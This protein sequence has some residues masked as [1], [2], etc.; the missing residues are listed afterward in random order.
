[1]QFLE[2]RSQW[3]WGGGVLRV[4]EAFQSATEHSVPS[5]PRVLSDMHMHDVITDKACLMTA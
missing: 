3:R 5:C 4:S 1:M 2:D